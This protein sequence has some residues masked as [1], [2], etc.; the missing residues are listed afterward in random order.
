MA[1]TKAVAS[2]MLKTKTL[3]V[4]KVKTTKKTRKNNRGYGGVLSFIVDV[5]TLIS[6]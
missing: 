6:F 2:K 4:K 1:K 5:W 3:S